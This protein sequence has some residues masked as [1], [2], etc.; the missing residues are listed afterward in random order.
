MVTRGDVVR[1]RNRDAR[2][3]EQRGTRYG[4]VVQ[5]DR[6]AALS[7]VIV[8]PTSRGANPSRFRPEIVVSDQTTRALAE[9]LR[10]FDVR[11]VSEPVGHLSAADQLA[12]DDALRLVLDLR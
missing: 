4:V 8:V 1:I 2:G 5:A 3:H 6:V 9:Q 10:A 7:T 12:V 11:N